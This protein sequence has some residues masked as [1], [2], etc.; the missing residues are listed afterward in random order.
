MRWVVATLVQLSSILVFWL[1]INDGNLTSPD[2]VLELRRRMAA[3][4]RI[5]PSLS[6]PESRGHQCRNFDS[7][8]KVIP[9]STV[10]GAELV[11]NVVASTSPDTYR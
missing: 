5:T 6:V 10:L 1:S 3:E 4:N 7:R 9:I 8:H 2:L 11:D